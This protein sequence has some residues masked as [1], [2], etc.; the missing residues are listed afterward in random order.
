MLSDFNFFLSLEHLSYLDV[1]VNQTFSSNSRRYMII[2]E[3]T[4]TVRCKEMF[5]DLV[6]VILLINLDRSC[7]S[8]VDVA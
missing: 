5:D 7:E 4:N 6:L 3:S 8:A 1:F 2:P